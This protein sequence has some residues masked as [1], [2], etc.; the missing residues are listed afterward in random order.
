MIFFYLSGLVFVY[1]YLFLTEFN[2][3]SLGMK[4]E[5]YYSLSCNAWIDNQH[6]VCF[7][8]SFC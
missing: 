6:P 1:N 4:T 2:L 8:R 3:T 5:T 7:T